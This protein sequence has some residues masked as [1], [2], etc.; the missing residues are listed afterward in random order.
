[1]RQLLILDDDPKC[2][3]LVRRFAAAVGITATSYSQ[4]DEFFA[5]LRNE[6]T[7]PDV[8][9]DLNMPGLD[10]LAVADRLADRNFDGR[11]FL[12]S[13]AGNTVLRSS[14]NIFSARGRPIAGILAKPFNLAD[15]RRLFATVKQHELGQDTTVESS[16]S[17]GDL[18]QKTCDDALSSLTLSFRPRADA[19]RRS[20]VGF[21]IRPTFSNKAGEPLPADGVFGLLENSGRLNELLRAYLSRCFAWMA[22]NLPPDETILIDLEGLWERIPDLSKCISAIFAPS[23]LKHDRVTF[24]VSIATGGERDAGILQEW[25]RMKL[26]G[27]G[28]A[29]KMRA[30]S[31][32]ET[33]LID[34]LPLSEIVIDPESVGRLE[35][36]DAV[37]QSVSSLVGAATALDLLITA[38]GIAGDEQASALAILGADI[39]QGDYIGRELTGERA[40]SLATTRDGQAIPAEFRSPVAAQ[41]ATTFLDRSACRL[42]IVDDEP[43]VRS[44][45]FRGLSQEGFL[46]RSFLSGAD[47]IESLRNETFDCCLL[48]FRMPDING[49]EVLDKIPPERRGMPVILFTSHGDVE[50]AVQ[51]MSNGAADV[52]EKPSSL[53][54]LASRIEERVKAAK[55]E[56][57]FVRQVIE[58]RQQLAKLTFREK[59]IAALVAQ[60]LTSKMIG[61]QLGLSARTVEAHRLNL[62]KKIDVQNAVELSRLYDQANSVLA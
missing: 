31:P 35:R 2:G 32:P 10:G 45:L 14:E 48:D 19:A 11:I 22:T 12:M 4:Q 43:L 3:A 37:R 15:F 16:A 18:S 53:A 24:M 25:V 9:L 5:A 54:K 39:L 60:G 59:E 29:L 40:A 28:L 13:G 51:A 36:D 26:A 47:F 34:L 33:Q 41:A 46:C 20:L 23:A 57:G 7:Q 1:M 30:D 58:A 49:L 55:P 52:V 27:F 44:T 6:G 61:E 56:A 17:L 50:L 62:M 8:I 21:A 42:A 38:D